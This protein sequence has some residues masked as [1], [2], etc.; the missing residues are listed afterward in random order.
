MNQK[1]KAEASKAKRLDLTT[2]F[3]D[4]F[5]KDVAGLYCFTTGLTLHCH[6]KGYM[7]YKV[8][9]SKKLKSRFYSYSLGHPQGVYMIALLRTDHYMKSE[10]ELFAFL[11]KRKGIIRTNLS[12]PIKTR[13]KSK[14]EWFQTKK[15]ETI[16]KAIRDFYELH[17]KDY[18]TEKFEHQKIDKKDPT[19]A[20]V[21]FKFDD[22]PYTGTFWRL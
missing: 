5:S 7:L 16:Q 9:M 10:K 11:E 4:L 17:R 13:L 14:G 20:L 8:G 12:E 3:N 18:F 1:E 19:P 6:N 15:V 22:E 21:L 2:N